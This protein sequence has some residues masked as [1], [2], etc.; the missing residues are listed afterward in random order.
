MVLTLEIDPNKGVSTAK[1]VGR[2]NKLSSMFQ[3]QKS[4]EETLKRKQQFQTPWKK[5]VKQHD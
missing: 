1:I 5:R 3:V 4:K 2:Y